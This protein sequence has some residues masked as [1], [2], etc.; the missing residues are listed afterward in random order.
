MQIAPVNRFRCAIGELPSRV[1]YRNIHAPTTVANMIAMAINL[2]PSKND[3]S[4]VKMNL[5]TL[6]ESN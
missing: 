1:S 2:L 6:H 5:G 4:M 3:P